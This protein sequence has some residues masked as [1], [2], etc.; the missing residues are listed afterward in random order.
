MGKDFDYPF[1]SAL[2]SKRLCLPS[3]VTLVSPSLVVESLARSSPSLQHLYISNPDD[4]PHIDM[5]T[6]IL[7]LEGCPGLKTLEC[8]NL[9]ADLSASASYA[10]RF[11]FC[12]SILLL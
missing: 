6:T 5:F 4:Q 11:R 9:S 1:R 7:G 3:L 2:S 12:N 8:D 10:F